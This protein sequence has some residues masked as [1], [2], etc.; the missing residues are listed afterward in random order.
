MFSRRLTML[1]FLVTA[2]PVAAQE[3]VQPG[4]KVKLTDEALRIHRD[5]SGH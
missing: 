4:P 2:A 5:R 3:R 1:L